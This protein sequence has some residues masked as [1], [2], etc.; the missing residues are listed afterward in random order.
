[1]KSRD[2]AIAG[3]VTALQIIT[4]LIS[5]IIPT[6]KLALLFAASVYPGVL[7]RIGVKRRTVASS[8]LAS[9]ALAVF[10]VQV[11]EIQAGFIALFGWYAI[12]HEGTKHMHKIRQQLIR[13]AGFIAAAGLVYI[14]FTYIVP[15]EIGYAL[16][17]IALAGIA[18]FIAMQLLYEFTVRELIKVTK[19]RLYDG[20]I[21]FK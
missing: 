8:F 2:I 21:M 13:W 18:A 11:P 3:I 5:Y 20:K 19:I 9:A 10:L 1:M 17:I 12:L 7:L 6:I 15:I 14:A 16:W 4:L